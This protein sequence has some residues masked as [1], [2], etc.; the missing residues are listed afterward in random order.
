M[1]KIILRILSMMCACTMLLCGAAGQGRPSVNISSSPSPEIELV[2]FD[3]GQFP[4]FG[5]IDGEPGFVVTNRSARAVVGLTILWTST[6]Q[7]GKRIVNMQRSDAFSMPGK[8]VV[9]HANSRLVA[10]PK[11]FFWEPLSSR[12][13]GVGGGGSHYPSAVP[14]D[15][16][17]DCVIFEDGELVG[18][19]DSHHDV[20][21]AS[22]RIAAASVVQQVRE[23]QG[24]GEPPETVLS[25][26]EH[27][28]MSGRADR[29]GFWTS[30]FASRLSQTRAGFL[31]S[32]LTNLQ[33][34]P[35]A[36]KF[37]RKAN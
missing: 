24:R 10:T 2:P 7:D 1:M 18:P 3:T 33:K 22:R 19:N 21:I 30:M 34:L 36:P 16:T 29:V 11:G 26:M 32:E 28:R 35:E 20:D 15:A 12:M 14:I 6:R 17:V 23:A 27:T 25:Q 4:A 9:L 37:F 5:T 13:Y 31:E 8:H